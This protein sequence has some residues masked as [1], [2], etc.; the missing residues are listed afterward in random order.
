MGGEG[1]AAGGPLAGGGKVVALSP[2]LGARRVLRLD[3][4]R[5]VLEGDVRTLRR[6]LWGLCVETDGRNSLSCTSKLRVGSRNTFIQ[7]DACTDC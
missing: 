2:V 7:A 3:G 5:L 4:G 6:R 1:P